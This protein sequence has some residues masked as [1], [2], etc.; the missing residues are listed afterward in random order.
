[1]QHG[2]VVAYASRQLMTLEINYPTHDLEL[3]TVVFALEI[4]RYYLY[5][6]NFE[7]FTD[8]K[9]LK[10]FT[11]QL[12]LKMRQCQWLEL[13]KDYDCE[14]FY[15]PG[16]AN[17]VADALSRKSLEVGAIAAVLAELNLISRI[18]C[19]QANN[20]EL[21]KKA[22]CVGEDRETN[23]RVLENGLLRYRNRVCVPNDNKLRD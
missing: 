5:G 21:K 13:L 15:H 8:H 11:N 2:K 22:K 20:D 10:Y 1:M 12:N 23:F 3:A 4:W 17:I 14:I 9:S 7:V 19:L 18:K 16:T 6:E